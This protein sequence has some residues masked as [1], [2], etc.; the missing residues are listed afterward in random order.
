M[1]QH[2]LSKIKFTPSRILI[3]ILLFFLIS[4]GIELFV[5]DIKTSRMQSLLFSHIAKKCTYELE[6]GESKDIR[7][8]KFG[9]Y[10]IRLGYS[11]IPEWIVKMSGE[12]YTVAKQAKWS[13]T[14]LRCVDM[15]LFAIYREKVQNGICLL[16]RHD[17][18][19]SFQKFPERI[20]PDFK[21]IPPV[22]ADM[23]LFIENRH[24]LDT[25]SQ[26]QNPSI[27]WERLF[28][29]ISEAV[30]SIFD[31]NRNVAG[32]STLS[33]QIE[34]FRHSPRGITNSARDKI[35]QISSSTLRTYYFGE[36]TS[37][38]RKRILLDYVNSIPLSAAPGFGEVLGLGDGLWA[39][40]GLDYKTV[41]HLLFDAR[42]KDI[43]PDKAA[44]IGSALKAVLS[45]F[46]SQRRPSAYLITHRNDLEEL[47]NTYCRLLEKEGVLSPKIRDA[48]ISTKLN[49]Q[50]KGALLYSMEIPQ[51]KA[52]NFIRSKL[53]TTL[54]MERLYDI[55][56]LDLDVKTGIDADL[57]HKITEVL[58]SLKDP[59]NII[60]AGLKGP[61]LLEKGDP[62]KII[63]SL[64]LYERTPVGNMLRVQTNN[65]DGSF[66]MDEQMKLDMGSSAKLRVLVHY[67]DIIDKLHEQYQNLPYADLK[68]LSSDPGLDP[69]TRWTMDFLSTASDKSL[70]AL[71]YAA[72]NRTY[73]AGVGERFF[74]GGGLHTF[75]NF[76]KE[77]NFKVISV[78]EAFQRSVNLVFIR[79]MRDIVYYHVYQRYGITPRS[80][81]KI[82]DTDRS[83]LLSQ[84][85]NKESI[86]FIRRFY[87]KYQG[88][89]PDELNELLYMKIYP[90]PHRLAAA[91]RLLKPEASVDEF[92]TFISNH[93]PGSHLTSKYINTLYTR[94][95]P[96]N[97]SLADIGYITHVH[98]LELW[99]V[100][101]LQNNPKATK[102]EVIQQ[103]TDKR[104]EVYSWLYKTKNPHKQYKRIRTI[105]ELEAFQDIH[106]EWKRLGYPF[107]Y[108]IPSYA[109]SIGSSGDRPAALAE[110]IGI[111]LNDGIYYPR[112]RISSF[113][114]GKDTPYET[115][116]TLSPVNGKQIIAPETALIVK[117]A[118]QDVVEQ[119][120]AS[121][122]KNAAVS[123]EGNTLIIG[124]KTGTGDHRYKT[125][126]PGG[127][128]ISSKV[129]N[130][131]AIFVFLIGDRHFGTISVYVS[132]N[133]A[134]NF[135]FSSSLPVGILK[136]L[137]PDIISSIDGS[138]ALM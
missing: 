11:R 79:M 76:N 120:T 97:F 8:P 138:Q 40:Y 27:E 57:Q 110:L 115:L 28:K 87:N 54:G 81:E 48:A 127:N 32:G 66:N 18:Q 80:I 86:Q 122:L 44:E 88:K 75:A 130:R 62:S 35:R 56:R 100:S 99:L 36:K 128:L 96:G 14:L 50:K 107:D 42:K 61:H 73:S 91:F 25:E 103:S 89:T 30:L 63:Y 117:K 69:L 126:G 124:G 41:N 45:L 64:S 98:P 21:S 116:M 114:F 101:F 123:S 108:L 137:L 29:S 39:W 17:K 72:M 112:K 52:T 70:Y 105:V 83:R 15:G 111:I 92:E 47:A 59:S 71:L 46:L 113:C 6:N 118:L 49:F 31:N 16:D 109:S 12:G 67:L 24:L 38:T 129:L 33:T 1:I 13:P 74:T 131:T 34:K 60:K 132:G 7:F 10:D 121:R 135:A 95:K 19:L 26:Y 43:P 119:G 65:F 78:R 2:L 68:L 93:L 94:Y 90:I 102:E 106:R 53:M 134:A 3:Y 85:V 58:Y 55:D 4:L 23:L 104:H 37:Q 136:I 20:Y 125:F 133:E 5:R 77:D 22:V 51:K 84:F 82:S 9:P